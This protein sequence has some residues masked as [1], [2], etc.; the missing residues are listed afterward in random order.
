MNTLIDCGVEDS[1]VGVLSL[2]RQQVKLLS[3]LLESHK[4]LEVLTADRSQGRDK[5]CIVISMVRSN[6]SGLVRLFSLFIL[7]VAEIFSGRRAYERLASPQ[8]FLYTSSIKTCN[9][10]LPKNFGGCAHA[11]RILRTYGCT[12]MDLQPSQ[13]RSSIPFSI[14]KET[15]FSNRKGECGPIS[16]TNQS[17]EIY[18]WN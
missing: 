16:Q 6:D 2:Y 13:L 15:R 7:S 8:C 5:D 12:R 11:Q 14:K 1:Q 10:W 18:S 3:N 17:G 4:K 9:L